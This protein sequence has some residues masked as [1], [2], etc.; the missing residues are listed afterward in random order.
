MTVSPTLTADKSALQGR[1]IPVLISGVMTGFA[2]V[3]TRFALGDIPPMILSLLRM[4]LGGVGLAAALIVLRRAMP[5][6]AVSYLHMLIGG[7]IGVGIPVIGFTLSL[8]HMSS[9]VSSV[10]TSL[11]PLATAIIEFVWL[12]ETLTRVRIGG[13]VMAFGGALVLILTRTTGLSEQSSD[14]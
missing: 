14:D 7:L 11:I 8:Q 4:L 1:I 5:T 3:V 13:L 12:K 2:V 6:R 10:F 9:G